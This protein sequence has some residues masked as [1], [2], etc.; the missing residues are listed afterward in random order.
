RYNALKKR[1]SQVPEE[2]IKILYFELHSPW[3]KGGDIVEKVMRKVLNE[4]TNVRLVIRAGRTNRLNK[5][6]RTTCF[7]GWIS[8]EDIV[9]L[10]D[11]CDILFAPSRGG[12]FELNVLE[13]LARGLVVV[14]SNCPSI[15]EYATEALIIKAKG[16]VPVLKR[17]PIHTGFG[18][19]PDPEHAYELVNYAIDNLEELKKKAEDLAPEIRQKYTWRKSAEKI[20]NILGKL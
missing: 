4:R 9:R 11:S 6:P 2:G 17:N 7:P 20:A 3:R 19:D 15:I 18:P 10:Y 14:T 5:L 12:A 8:D 1:L 16:Q 13:A